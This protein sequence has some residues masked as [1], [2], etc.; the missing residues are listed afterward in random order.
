MG[1]LFWRGEAPAQPLL[2]PSPGVLEQRS[3]EAPNLLSHSAPSPFPCQHS[4]LFQ[5]LL[6]GGKSSELGWEPGTAAPQ[7][8]LMVENPAG[9]SGERLRAEFLPGRDGGMLAPGSPRCLQASDPALSRLSAAGS[10][11]EEFAS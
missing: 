8:G 1:I 5:L 2:P 11:D 6:V 9:C 7:G 3:E 10:R 4:S